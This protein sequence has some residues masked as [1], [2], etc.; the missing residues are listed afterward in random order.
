MEIITLWSPAYQRWLLLLGLR[1]ATSGLFITLVV[2]IGLEI[3]LA[4]ASVVESSWLK[5]EKVEV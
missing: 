3:M 4:M 1:E 5:E 2:A